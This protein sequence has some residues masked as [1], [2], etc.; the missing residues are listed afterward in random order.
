MINVAH[1]VHSDLG[2]RCARCGARFF[3]NR[4]VLCDPLRL[5]RVKELIAEKH[6]RQCS[7]LLGTKLPNTRVM[8][9]VTGT[10]KLD[11]Y[12]QRAMRAMNVVSVERV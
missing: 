9:I 2:I 7:P 4:S 11:A 5:L 10:E 3:A 1:L 8:A 6:R 12:W